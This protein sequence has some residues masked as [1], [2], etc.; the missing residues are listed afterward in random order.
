MVKSQRVQHGGGQ[1]MHASTILNRFESKLV[2]CAE[3]GSAFNSAAGQPHAKAPMIVVSAISGFP[4]ACQL[5]R[6][7]A[8][9]FTAQSTSVSSNMPRCFKS[10][11]KAAIGSF[12][13]RT[14]HF[15]CA[16]ALLAV[17]IAAFGL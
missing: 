15:L 11:S 9:E 4:I 6:Q 8:A 5:N 3:N 7:S 16:V 17:A 2:G 12:R 10:V 1:I 13:F 14:I